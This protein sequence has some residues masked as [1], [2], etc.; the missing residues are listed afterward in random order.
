MKK[1]C[2]ICKYAKR[3]VEYIWNVLIAFDQF[4]NA[5]LGGDPDETI[6][7]RA[8]KRQHE[9]KWAKALC[10]FLNKLDTDHCL[11]S[12]EDDEGKNEIIK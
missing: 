2:K 7:S 5:L 12:I 3:V 1:D 9:Q 6:S 11:K 4:C 8:G 10:W